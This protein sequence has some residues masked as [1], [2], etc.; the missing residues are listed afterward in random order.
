VASVHTSTNSIGPAQ[1]S[2]N[3]DRTQGIELV[4]NILEELTPEDIKVAIV[5]ERKR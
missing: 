1:K 4:I 2:L 5:T 3:N